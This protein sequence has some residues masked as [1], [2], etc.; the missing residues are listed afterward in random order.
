MIQTLRV[1]AASSLLLITSNALAAPV[2]D[3][4]TLR[5]TTATTLSGTGNTDDPVMGTVA[6]TADGA[7]LI[8]YFTPQTLTNIGDSLTLSYS[9]SFTEGTIA[10][11]SDNWR[12][13]L[14]DGTAEAQ[15]ATNSNL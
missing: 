11:A 1:A 10:S 13:A 2:T 15:E 14:Y 8:G 12:Y 7:R 9:V 5:G 3:F 6:E 4:F